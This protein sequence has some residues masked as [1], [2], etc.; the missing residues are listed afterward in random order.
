MI[1]DL[2]ILATSAVIALD[3]IDAGMFSSAIAVAAV[4]L[5]GGSR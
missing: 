3:D 1:R 4:R 2:Q 5:N